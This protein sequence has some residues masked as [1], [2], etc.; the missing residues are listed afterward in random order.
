[1]TRLPAADV[2]YFDRTSR[3][4][5]EFARHANENGCLVVFEPSS[6][7]EPA[8]LAE[9]LK[10]AHIVKIASDRLE[11]NERVLGAEEPL[12]LVETQGSN[13]LRFKHRRAKGSGRW[14]R[15][16]AFTHS[17]VVDTAGAGDWCTAGII[18]RLG[19]LGVDGFANASS[20]D[21]I[22]ALR[23]G[24]AMA[25]WT[26]QFHGA[27]GGM[28][29]SSKE[30]FIQMIKAMLDGDREAKCRSLRAR[31]PTSNEPVWCDSC[32]GRE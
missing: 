11:G 31:K 18:S 1:M 3:G 13:G 25:A 10:V 4:A 26:C 8:L 15:V 30:D 7:S 16:A 2:F 28:Y 22:S 5:V 29:E 17:A 20:D 24:Q 6:G 12:L 27:R 19:P 14:K 21:V 9:A 32:F 23:L